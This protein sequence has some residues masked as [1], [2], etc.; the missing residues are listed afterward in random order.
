MPL[1]GALVRAEVRLASDEFRETVA[2]F[3]HLGCDFFEPFQHATSIIRGRPFANVV[4]HW[5]KAPLGFGPRI[6]V[7]SRNSA[8]LATVRP[9]SVPLLFD[10]S[11]QAR[12]I[13]EPLIDL[14]DQL[15]R[16]RDASFLHPDSRK[17]KRRASELASRSG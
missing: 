7:S 14:L 17:S 4:A 3:S 13:A 6:V 15:L 11:T 8:A 12:R 2:E 10:V 5:D 9:H 1:A 16:F